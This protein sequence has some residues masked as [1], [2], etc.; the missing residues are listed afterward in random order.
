MAEVKQNAQRAEEK[1]IAYQKRTG[2][3][4]TD[5]NHNVLIERLDAIN[6]QLVVSEANRIAREAR[7]RMSL[8]GDPEALVESQQGSPL[9]VLHAQKATLESQYAQAEQKFGD[10]YPR[11]LE[12][13][14]QLDSTNAAL[15]QEVARSQDKLWKEYETA[16]DAETG[17]RKAFERQKQGVYDTNEAAIQ[18]ALLKRDVDVSRDLY[19]QLIKQAQR[20]WRA[21]GTEVHERHDHRS[22]KDSGPSGGAATC[23]ESGSRFVCR[24]AAW[25]RSVLHPGER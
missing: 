25:T 11:V 6:Q 21:R 7:Y 1:F 5:E 16:V 4:G 17:L 10:A 20:G 2:V 24:V 19:E 12:L 22:R 13:K 8:S 18:V 9:L 15:G 3:I 14:A 23:S